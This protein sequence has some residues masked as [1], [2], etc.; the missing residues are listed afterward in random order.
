[1]LK[2]SDL[3]KQLNEIAPFSDSEKWDNTGLLV[4]NEGDTV[5]GIITAL[6]CSANT[7]DEAVMKNAN[8]II[9]HHP[10][11]FP[12]ISKVVNEG[13]GLVIQKLIKNDINLIAM[14]TNL[15]HQKNG[16]SHMIAA[17][18]GYPETEILLPEKGNFKKLRVN[19]NTRDKEE[20]KQNL[21]KNAPVGDMGD[22]TEVSYEYEVH[23]QFKPEA[24]ANP[25]IGESGKLEHVDEYIIECIFD[26]RDQHAVIDAVRKYH[27]YEE[28]AFDV[29]SLDRAADTGL[30]VKFNYG[31]TLDSLVQLIEK[32][33]GLKTVN[34]V[35]ADDRIIN[36]AAVIGGAG[37][38]YR[39]AAFN[40]GIDVLITGDVKYHEAYDAKAAGHNII[41]AGHYLEVLMTSGLRELIEDELDVPV[42]ASE[43][44]TN[45]FE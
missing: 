2:I 3:L 21:L 34:V 7:V 9:S 14:H 28:P 13:P 23:G 45:P 38:S 11:I 31:D 12:E 40:S 30:G 41:D 1:M 17:A 29:Y 8:V 27:P 44:S 20:F 42:T 22:Y 37:M 18:L 32:K 19:I 33:T 10:L 16:V 25:T 43:V 36:T 24:E 5:T 35:R 6:D 26:G 4:G 15:D 39:E